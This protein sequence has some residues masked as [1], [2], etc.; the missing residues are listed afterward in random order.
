[1]PF[2]RDIIVFLQSFSSSFLDGVFKVMAYCFDYPLVIV[3]GLI[4]IIFKK[5]REAIYFLLL[6]GVCAGVQVS[7]K[8]IV[9]RSRPYVSY[10]EIRN[11][12][13]ASNSSFPSGHSITCMVAVVVLWAMFDGSSLKKSHKNYCKAGLVFALVLCLINRMYLGQHYLTDVIGGFVI[14]FAISFPT[15]KFLY[16]KKSKKDVYE[17]ETG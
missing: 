6:E 7:L 16:L 11:V 1:M 3:L 12:L 17:K 10:S 5:Y 2:E 13:Q 15:M 4:L 9:S 14:A 8:A